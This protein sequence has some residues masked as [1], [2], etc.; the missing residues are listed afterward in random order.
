M[1]RKV[2]I[3][4]TIYPG[5]G[6]KYP[7]NFLFLFSHFVDKEINYLHPKM[8]IFTSVGYFSIITLHF[9]FNKIEFQS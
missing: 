6:L 7:A 5:L 9:I 2:I 3:T 8:L 1:V 4:V